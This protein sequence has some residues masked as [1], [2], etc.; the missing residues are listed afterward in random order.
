LGEHGS[1][2]RLLRKR[3]QGATGT[4]YAARDTRSNAIVAVKVIKGDATTLTRSLREYAVGRMV[5]SD[6]IVPLLRYWLGEQCVVSVMPWIE[7]VSLRELLDAEGPLEVEQCVWIVREIALAL[8]AA[9]QAGIVHRDVKPANILIDISGRPLICDFGIA[10]LQDDPEM[11]GAGFPAGTP[12]Y[13]SPEQLEGTAEPASDQYALGIV[14]FE[15]LTGAR[16]YIGS[17]A[18]IVAAHLGSPPPEFGE[19]VDTRG[20]PLP[21]DVTTVLNRMVQKSPAERLPGLRAVA[22]ALAPHQHEEVRN[23][24]AS[25]VSRV[26]YRR[27]L[28]DRVQLAVAQRRAPSLTPA[29]LSASLAETP[30]GA[31]FLTI[32][33][34][35]VPPARAPIATPVMAPVMALEA[36]PVALPVANAAD[37][38]L[39]EAP[40]RES[41]ADRSPSMATPP[42]PGAEAPATTTPRSGSASGSRRARLYATAALL[43]AMA[44]VGS[45]LW[46]RRP[47]GSATPVGVI[48]VP[49]ITDSVRADSNTPAP[50]AV[51]VPVV[52]PRAE[53]APTEPRRT[54]P[55]KPRVVDP[56]KANPESQQ[57]RSPVPVTPTP[58]PIQDSGKSI[59]PDPKPDPVH[60]PVK[61]VVVPDSSAMRIAEFRRQLSE[62]SG[63]PTST[64]ERQLDGP[65]AKK[66]ISELKPVNR[67]TN[68]ATSSDDDAARGMGSILFCVVNGI[69]VAEEWRAEIRREQQPGTGSR[70]VVVSWTN[71]KR[72]DVKC[73]R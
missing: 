68:V 18:L 22:D 40:I 24:I 16:P 8:A 38:P 10:K 58:R 70:W 60:F 59:V 52:A 64:L 42:H 46:K 41:A 20:N 27:F 31:P 15:L 71:I 7:G 13:M 28:A 12:A 2:Y 21:V 65:A 48:T 55:L 11:T 44:G 9:H 43:L 35:V 17:T 14:A 45:V 23:V 36:T 39:G 6:G 72:K 62:L 33:S 26:R 1:Q 73:A 50:R 63:Q 25:R 5:K 47:S 30:A 57:K 53:Q 56:M 37:A 54:E 4:V 29:S 34:P 51:E 49:S 19:L 61:P 3:A 66:M 32:E 67:K 69:G